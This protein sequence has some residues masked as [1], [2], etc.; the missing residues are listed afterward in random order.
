MV[1]NSLVGV[2]RGL[3]FD[4]LSSRSP[5]ELVQQRTGRLVLGGYE[6]LSHQVIFLFCTRGHLPEEMNTIPC[7]QESGGGG[8]EGSLVLCDQ[9]FHKYGP[10]HVVSCLMLLAP[11]PVTS[12]QK[13]KSRSLEE[14]D[15]ELC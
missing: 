2:V 14:K 7:C 13:K 10:R 3:I 6:C 4:E 9:L 15:H 5:N 12:S 8:Q 11:C 1:A